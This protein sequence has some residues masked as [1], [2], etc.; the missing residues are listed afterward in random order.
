MSKVITLDTLKT[1]LVRFKDKLV[2]SIPSVYYI[3][4]N[5]TNEQKEQARKNIE[6][7]DENNGLTPVNVTYINP[8]YGTKDTSTAYLLQGT[9]KVFDDD[10][11]TDVKQAFVIV[12]NVLGG[13]TVPKATSC[14]DLFD[15]LRILYD[16]GL[17]TIPFKAYPNKYDRN[18]WV[19]LSFTYQN[20]GIFFNCV[21]SD[22]ADGFYVTLCYDFETSAYVKESCYS[23]QTVKSSLKGLTETP[24]I[25]QLQIQ[26]DPT[27]DKEIA[28]KGYVDRCTISEVPTPSPGDIGTV[29]GVVQTGENQAGYNFVH[30]ITLPD[31]IDLGITGATVG[32]T[33]KVRAVTDTDGTPTEWEA[34]DMPSGGNYVLPQATAEILGGVKADP[35]TASD[36]QPVHINEN[37]KL[38]TAPTTGNS[39]GGS[40]KTETFDGMELLASGTIASGTAAGTKTDTGVTYGA[41]KQWHRVVFIRRC[42]SN[43]GNICF[44]YG[45]ENNLGFRNSNANMSVVYEHIDGY[46]WKYHCHATDTAAY[47]APLTAIDSYTKTLWAPSFSSTNNCNIDD[48]YIDIRCGIQDEKLNGVNLTFGDENTFKIKNWAALTADVNW[49][50][51]GLTK[52]AD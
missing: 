17:I 28:T 44:G 13:H 15:R 16:N 45:Y 37:G 27:A 36:T 43:Q 1:A 46:L 26:S 2:E 5:L 10:S 33:I 38:V 20:T 49:Y 8:F 42:A 29:L 11:P 23:E 12:M 30:L 52:E 32:Q 34:V 21:R 14:R 41:F 24:T 48:G 39:T 18:Y 9:L 31:V 6:A 3:S 25:A 47:A 22:K 50:I 35:A 7:Q 40:G 51:Y 4:Q 19:S